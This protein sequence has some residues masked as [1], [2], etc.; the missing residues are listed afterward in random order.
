M[1]HKILVLGAVVSLVVASACS[2]NSRDV[3]PIGTAPGPNP[4]VIPA[5]ITPAYV[6]AVF[7]VLNHINGNAVRAYV[8]GGV[9]TPQAKADLRAIYGEP[10]YEKELQLTSESLNGSLKNVRRPPGDRLTTVTQLIDSSSQCIFVATKTSYAQIL[11]NPSKPAASEYWRLSPKDPSSDPANLNP[12][13]W[14]ISFNASYT[15]PTT[16][17]DQCGTG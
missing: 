10:L 4:D 14:S 12:T 7:K 5:I 2:S 11:M 6:D 8:L 15:T 3:H 17:P 9:L 16:I 13:D 1:R